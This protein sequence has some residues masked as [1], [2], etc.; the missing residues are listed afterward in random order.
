MRLTV[1]Q[2][3][4]GLTDRATSTFWGDAPLGKT[5]LTAGALSP[6]SW[7]FVQLIVDPEHGARLSGVKEG[8][9]AESE[10]SGWRKAKSKTSGRSGRQDQVGGCMG[11]VSDKSCEEGRSQQRAGEG[12]WSQQANGRIVDPRPDREQDELT[13]TRSDEQPRKTIN[14]R[15]TSNGSVTRPFINPMV[16][17]GDDDPKQCVVTRIGRSGWALASTRPSHDGRKRPH[18]TSGKMIPSCGIVSFRTS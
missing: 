16:R 11:R 13:G 5:S 4:A 6:A 9:W 8:I 18:F 1:S 14:K 7:H 12:R 10:A 17:G 2:Y 15:G 3:L